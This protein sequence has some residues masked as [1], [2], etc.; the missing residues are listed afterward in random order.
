MTDQQTIDTQEEV[1]S[2]VTV[3]VVDKPEIT[4]TKKV[5]IDSPLTDEDYRLR[6][7]H[8]E[9]SK[10][11]EVLLIAEGTY[12]FHWGGVSTWCHLLIRD[13][14]EVNY[15]LYSLVSD[16]RTKPRINLL[17]NV[18]KFIPMPLWGL[19]QVSELEEELPVFELKRRKQQTTEEVIAAK[20]V[21][22]F[23]AF[24]DELYLNDLE[25]ELMAVQIHQMY[26]YFLNYDFD[27]TFRSHSVWK[28]FVEAVKQNFPLSAT[29]HGYPEAEYSL[30]DV[31]Q[32][33]QWLYHWFFPLAR[34]IPKVDIAHASMAGISTMIGVIVKMEYGGAFL[35]SEHGIYLRERYLAEA[36]TSNTLFLKLLMLRFARRMTDISYAL[37]D[38]ISPCCDYNQ[39]WEVQNGASP[40]RLR[41]IYYGADSDKFYA[42]GKPIGDP[43]IVVWVGRISPLK[44]LFTLLQAAAL[45]HEDRPDIKFRLYGNPPAEDKPY[46]EE[47]LELRDRL[48]L[49]EV[50]IFAGYASNPAI[51]YNEGDVV[52]LSSIS[53][54]FPFATLEAMLC[55]KPV[56]AT[57]VGG[58][59]EQIEGCGVVVEPRNPRQMADGVLQ[60]MND[61]KLCARLGK[62]AREKALQEF[63]VHQSRE[64]Y[65]SSYLNIVK[66][67][68][69]SSFLEK[70]GIPKTFV[71]NQV[72]A[73]MPGTAFASAKGE[74]LSRSYPQSYNGGRQETIAVL[75]RGVNPDQ[76]F[77]RKLQPMG[78]RH[79]SL[80]TPRDLIPIIELAHEILR[81]DRNPIDYLEVA[82]LL[83]SMGTTD[84]FANQQYG[85]P[86]TFELA[87]AVLQ[88]MRAENIPAA[89]IPPMAEKA[90]YTFRQKIQ[91]YAQGPI[92]FLAS[93]IVLIV[94]QF[95]NFI[96]Q[97]SSGQVMALGL[98]MSGGLLMTNGIFQAML[99][100]T[101]ITLT[102]NSPRAAVRFLLIGIGVAGL[103][104][105]GIASLTMLVLE[106]TGGFNFEERLTFCLA[107]LAVATI[108]LA[109]IPLALLRAQVWLGI[110][111]TAGLVLGFAVDRFTIFF[112]D[113]HLLYGTITGFIITLSTIILVEWRLFK[114]KFN[115]SKGEERI[116]LPSA[117]FLADEA[118]SYFVYGMLYA[119]FIILSHL[120]GW[121]G[122]LAEGQTWQSAV[123]SLEVGLTLSLPPMILVGG[124]MEHTLRLFWHKTSVIQAGTSGLNA[125]QFGDSLL[126]F[127]R[128]E[129]RRYQIL[130]AVFSL[131]LGI[132][133]W[134]LMKDGHLVGLIGSNPVPTIG[135]FLSGL[136]IYFLLGRA[137]F[138][139][140]FCL[141][142]A[143]PALA[144]KAIASGLVVMLLLGLP[145]SLM[146]D[147][148]YSIIGVLAGMITFMMVSSKLTSRLLKSADYYYFAAF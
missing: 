80:W 107:F 116:I 145:L 64:A 4:V 101:S 110:G 57:S 42:G 43:P 31:T 113:Q 3:E 62:A 47:C 106:W 61:P 10:A 75:D 35:L 5:I 44:D 111:L 37:S 141:T 132:P 140:T 26:T 82:A 29:Q 139:C 115:A 55:G 74:K 11:L 41:T 53:E 15:S 123:T 8:E 83:E 65:L 89:K 130:L 71:R 108:W 88:V 104:M 32:G 86:D 119:G 67:D 96:G 95:Y 73:R 144:A 122:K 92:A 25:P 121:F 118:T 30:W 58:L 63:S 54:G 124:F 1:S 48:G 109:A 16:P 77:Q 112:S 76:Q 70:V 137:L 49:E 78:S 38:Q 136:V 66:R 24:L 100:R 45:V 98:G 39:R 103:T 135:F 36:D 81:R 91:H 105:A 126:S 17:P 138:N 146:I 129:G 60:L 142:L 22:I 9:Q 127:Y 114:Y 84:D 93:F 50:V 34:P 87:K 52:L 125:G 68:L 28:C 46:Y 19:L 14:P 99:R 120:L 85:A 12:P 94:I 97:W 2:L 51:A 6:N 33:L 21:P 13:L 147:F 7:L 56:V 102:L 20:F 18:T 90:P 23:R 133:L 131:V 72:A 134:I 40:E 117:A 148:S 79:S 128:R 27:I 59:P 143:R 69:P